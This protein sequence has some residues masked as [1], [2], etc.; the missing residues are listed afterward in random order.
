MGGGALVFGF[1]WDRKSDAGLPMSMAIACSYCARAMPRLIAADCALLQSCLRF[2]NG[3]LVA[4]AGVIGS[5]H[6]FER[7]LVG[8]HCVIE[9]LLQRI[10]AAN[11]KE[12][13]VQ[14][15]LVRSAV[16]SQG[17]PR[18]VALYIGWHEQCC[19]LFPRD[20]APRKHRREERTPADCCRS[21]VASAR[22]DPTLEE[23]CDRV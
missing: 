9:D 3:D 10:L 12:V 1:D 20:L 18:S 22:W 4:N 13:F 17:R 16:H 6:S 15:W 7:F 21:V 23:V 2:D 14:G 11:L 5:P 19:A 8:I